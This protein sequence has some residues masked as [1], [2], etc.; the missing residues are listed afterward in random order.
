MGAG[1]G[2]WQ[3]LQSLRA[4]WHPRDKA[5]VDTLCGP[6]PPVP[7]MVDRQDKAPLKNFRLGIVR[8]KMI[9]TFLKEEAVHRLS[10]NLWVKR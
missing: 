3:R 2:A 7:G 6:T 1:G 8:H 4:G 10:W 5:S 9:S